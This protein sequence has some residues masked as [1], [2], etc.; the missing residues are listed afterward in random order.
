VIS[1]SGVS[2]D[3][4]KIVDVQKWP[5]PGNGKELRGFLGLSWYYHK[6]VRSYGVISQPLT[7]LL[8]KGVQFVWTTEA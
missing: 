5:V 4:Q 3:P 1:A 7:Q 8:R 6:F 2:T